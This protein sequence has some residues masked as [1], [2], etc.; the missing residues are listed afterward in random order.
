MD[1]KQYNK[2]KRAE[3]SWET[4][5]AV[6]SALILVFLVVAIV[7]LPE[8]VWSKIPKTFDKIRG[9]KPSLTEQQKKGF[10]SRYT[11]GVNSFNQGTQ[12]G[13]QKAAYHFEQYVQNIDQVIAVEQ[14]QQ[15]KLQLEEQKN[16]AQFKLAQSFQ[17]LGEKYYPRAIQEYG[18]F[19]QLFPS[20]IKRSEAK[21]QLAAM[22]DLMG[23]KV[24]AEDVRKE[25]F[26]TGNQVTAAKE[27][28]K[29]GNYYTLVIKDYS[30]ALEYYQQGLTINDNRVPNYPDLPAYETLQN[31][32]ITFAETN[33]Y[34]DAQRFLNILKDAGYE[35]ETEELV[36]KYP[37]LK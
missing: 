21:T 15:K 36:K 8:K 5:K 4:V 30:K 28:F 23:N 32:I 26:E 12:E 3:M 2:N 13:Y 6:L 29:Q 14:D 34:T 9:A 19:I 16:D 1:L 37:K 22:Y 20:D 17:A 10:D 24:A 33:L 18:K 31:M 7:S 25:L 35:K 27:A 11:V